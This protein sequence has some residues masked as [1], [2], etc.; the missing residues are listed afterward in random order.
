[1]LIALGIT[2]LVETMKHLGEFDILCPL[3]NNKIVLVDDFSTS[4]HKKTEKEH[5]DPFIR[6][7]IDISIFP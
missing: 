4:K 3:E 6:P 1:M 7:S 2:F 5:S